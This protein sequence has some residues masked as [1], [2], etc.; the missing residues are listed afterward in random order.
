M[1]LAFYNPER[2]GETKGVRNRYLPRNPHPT[3]LRTSPLSEGEGRPSK[4]FALKSSPL[5]RI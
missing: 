5:E 4:D 1:A 3:V 2:L